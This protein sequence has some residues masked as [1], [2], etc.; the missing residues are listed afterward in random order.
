[1]MDATALNAAGAVVATA[2]FTWNS[3]DASIA[4]V[5]GGTVTGIKSGNATITAA[6]G[7]ASGSIAVTVRPVPVSSVTVAPDTSTLTVG[8]TRQLAAVTRDSSGAVLANRSVSW[9]SSNTAVATV[10]ATGPATAL[11]TAMTPGTAIIT[12]TS[13]GRKSTTTL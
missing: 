11:A 5:V 10:S 3:S 1:K 2:S 9:A 12:A 13:E 4:T 6:S 8:Q 7:G